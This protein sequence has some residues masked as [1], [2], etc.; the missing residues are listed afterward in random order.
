MFTESLEIGLSREGEGVLDVDTGLLIITDTFLKEVGL[1][2][3]AD[4]LHEVKGVLGLVVLLTAEGDQE[5]VSDKLNVLL[6]HGA[7]HADEGTREGLSQELLLD[8]DGFGDDAKD[9]LAGGLTLEMLDQET[10][11][12]GVETFVTADE[13]VG[14]GETGHQATLLEPKDGSKGTG[15]EDTLNSSKGNETLTKGGVVIAD[16]SESPI[17]LLGYTWH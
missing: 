3:E 5:T 6:H 14:E 9:G 12:V 11:K 10:G 1:S 2:L 4:E 8:D 17:G 16:P 15:E 7:I 13:L